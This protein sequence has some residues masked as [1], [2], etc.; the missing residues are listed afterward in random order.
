MPAFTIVVVGCAVALSQPGTTAQPTPPAAAQPTAAGPYHV[1]NTF[2]VGGEGSWDYL[3]LDPE[4][5]RLFVP[6]GTH[7]MILDAQSGTV[8]GDIADTAGV[9]GVAL[10]ADLGKGF[11]SNGRTGTVTVFDLK[12]YKTVGTVKVGDNPDSILFEPTTKRVF[13]FNGRS[14]DVTVIGAEDLK[15]AGTIP[16]GGKPEFSVADGTG[17]IF[18]N[19]EDTSELLRI[20]AKSMKVEERWKLAPGAEPS[21]LAFDPVHKRLF[22][23]CSN[24]KMV[25]LD[26]E[27]GKVM[28]SPAIGKGTDGAG[29]DPAGGGF[30]LSSN[31]DGTM[32]VVSTKDDRFE[33]AQ[34]LTTAARARTM[35]ID[36]RTRRIYLPTAE[37]EAA[38]PAKEGGKDAR[39]ARP[40]MKP[41]TFKILVVTP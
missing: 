9:H 41:G 13:T 32:T 2:N 17:K 8:L 15:V 1:A 39:P 27:S 34:T 25:V 31:G 20:D 18:V 29:F 12:D 3:C 36:P 23:V 6:R 4:G 40:T 5:K 22:A 28:A 35:A 19:V 37:F 30:A 26:A 16:L 38:P 11:T 10:A 14:K 7:T 33:V 21:G 24:E